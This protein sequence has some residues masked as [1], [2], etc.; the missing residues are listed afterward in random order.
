M[1]KV[2]T[3]LAEFLAQWV[4]SPSELD[5][6]VASTI[7]EIWAAIHQPVIS[8]VDKGKIIHSLY[9]KFSQDEPDGQI[10][11]CPKDCNLP[12]TTRTASYR[13]RRHICPCGYRATVKKGELD[14]TTVLGARRLVKIAFPQDRYLA[15]WE[16][17]KGK[18]KDKDSVHLRPP[19]PV[20]RRASSSS[21]Q[22]S[23]SSSSSSSIIL[24]VP[25]RPSI[26]TI[27]RSQSTSAMSDSRNP[28]AAPPPPSPAE[29]DQARPKKRPT[30]KGDQGKPK[31][32]RK[33]QDG[34]S[35]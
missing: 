3:T 19:S 30:T 27:H 5:V 35:L 32:Q 26:S 33:R 10:V 34:P 2:A 21:L 12:M 9:T 20:V 24:R 14:G 15:D 13:T 29:P 6:I 18:D 17:Y 16:L 1:A 25:L 31:K 23:A 7:S 11:V 28:H 8:M 4:Q 22:P